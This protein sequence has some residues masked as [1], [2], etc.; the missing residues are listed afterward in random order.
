[1]ITAVVNQTAD[2]APEIVT[3]VDGEP[4]TALVDGDWTKAARLIGGATTAVVTIE[5]VADGEY[6]ISFTPTAVGNWAVTYSVTLDGDDEPT[7]FTPQLVQVQTAAQADPAAAL[8]ATDITVVSPVSETS[9]IALVIGDA[10]ALSWDSDGWADLTGDTVTFQ[11][12]KV[13]TDGAVF[14]TA[15][16]VTVTDAGEAT[17]TLAITLSGTQTDDFKPGVL[18]RYEVNA[19]DAGTLVSGSLSARGS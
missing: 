9:D 5:H 4:V 13:V 11:A 17:Q 8:A 1:M 18:Y 7:R 16:A 15:L 12:Y 10:A 2:C 19:E 3:D 6:D 14:A